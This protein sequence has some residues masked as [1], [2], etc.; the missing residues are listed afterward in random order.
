MGSSI[1]K[2]QAAS[3]PKGAPEREKERYGRF[4]EIDGRHDFQKAVPDGFVPYRVR[5]RRGSEVAYFN[6][7]L[8]REMGLISYDH[9]GKLDPELK[10]AL[11]DT[12]ALVIINEYD[13]QN[14][15]K[16]NPSEIRKNCY[17]ATRYLQLQ[18]PDK[19]GRTSG[20]GRSIWNGQISHRGVTWDISSCGTGATRLSPA[21]AIQKKFFKTGDPRV[22]YGCGYASLDEGLNAALM[23]EILHRSGVPTERTLAILHFPNENAAI[24]VRASQNLIRPSHFFRYLKIGDHEG[25]KNITDYFIER[26]IKNGRLKRTK[27]PKKQYRE[28]LKSITETYAKTTALFEAEYIFIWMD[29]D[30][31]NILAGDAGIIDYGS[32]RQFGLFHKDYRFDDVERFSTTIKEQRLK[33]RYI[34]Q[35]FV[36]LVDF[37]ETGKK[38]SLQSYRNDRHLK[39]FDQCFIEEKHRLVLHKTG[40]DPRTADLLW[41]NHEK[42]VRSYVRSFTYFEEK[43]SRSGIREVPDGLTSDAVFCMRDLLRE[44]PRALSQ[45]EGELK[46]IETKRFLSLAASSYAQPRDLKVT[47]YLESRV[48]KF[49]KLYRELLEKSAALRSSTAERALLEIMM[50]ASL[51]N[52]YDRVTGNAIIHVSNY[53]VRIRKR[54]GIDPFLKLVRRFVQHLRLDTPG[55]T[56]SVQELSQK[57]RKLIEIVREFRE[58][59]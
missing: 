25:L 29:W 43:Q 41:K 26:Q 11:V 30:G 56:D 32:V 39:L 44:Y 27:D 34:V 48:R 7:E 40:F 15:R 46:P 58:T 20:D 49:Q 51:V 10:K 52:P 6:F 50:R 36:Q 1:R 47:P 37:V 23:S 13:I 2:A 57:E 8:A 16:F 18:H 28:F 4:S 53:L 54:I 59:I 45:S 38:K 35:N 14:E 22:S 55:P 42:L 33:A 31:D 24:N 9:P 17:M 19:C 12:F 5:T 3:R 21:T